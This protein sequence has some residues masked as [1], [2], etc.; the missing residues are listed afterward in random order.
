MSI[1]IVTDFFNKTA[2]ELDKTYFPDVK[3]Y[4]DN[5]NT[6]E[7]HYS[8]ELFNNGCLTYTKLINRLSKACNET[9]EN[10]HKIVSKYIETF[11]DYKYRPQKA[12][13]MKTAVITR[14]VFGKNFSFRKG[15]KVYVAQKD[16][17]GTLIRIDKDS[18]IEYPV[19]SDAVEIVKTKKF[20]DCIIF[21]DKTPKA[22]DKMICIQ[23]NNF[24]YK[25]VVTATKQQ[26]ELGV[27]DTKNW[28]VIFE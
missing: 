9:K 23:K 22:G 3:Y 5:K 1:K 15:E 20:G 12:N 11:G 4:R 28:K 14:K 21:S 2:S 19:P 10:I 18:N 24:N 7:I 6:T 17:N 8:L 16:V 26:V 25:K 13:N 27:I